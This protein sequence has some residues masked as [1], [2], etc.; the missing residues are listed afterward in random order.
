MVTPLVGRQRADAS[1]DSMD[2]EL[3]DGSRS[4]TWTNSDCSNG[5]DRASSKRANTTKVL[6]M[7]NNS[8]MR[9]EL[10]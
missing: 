1:K 5:I 8:K 4:S 10:T 9:T 3:G 7:V 2:N 6:D